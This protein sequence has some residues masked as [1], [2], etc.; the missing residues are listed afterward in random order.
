M[1]RNMLAMFGFVFG[2]LFLVHG[3]GLLDTQTLNIAWPIVVL[4]ASAAK[5]FER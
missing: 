5:M 1:G 3:L 2:F 4:L